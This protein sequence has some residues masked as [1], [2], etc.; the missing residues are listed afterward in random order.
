MPDSHPWLTLMPNG[1]WRCTGDHPRCA[2][3]YAILQIQVERARAVT[4]RRLLHYVPLPSDAF[5]L[6]LHNLGMPNT[7]GAPSPI[8]PESD[9]EDDYDSDES[10]FD[11]D[12]DMPYPITQFQHDYD[13]EDDDIEPTP[14]GDL[15]LGP[16]FA[17]QI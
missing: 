3:R 17:T 16:A 10:K 7:H 14:N 8:V 2:I 12:A 11:R 5:D 13:G 1:N 15:P 9:I 6:V 4:I